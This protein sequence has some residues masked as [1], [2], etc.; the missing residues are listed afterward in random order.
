VGR[1]APIYGLNR[2]EK[3]A[4]TQPR[5]PS[6]M[7]FDKEAQ[8]LGHIAANQWCYGGST[9]VKMIYRV[10]WD[11]EISFHRVQHNV[12]WSDFGRLTV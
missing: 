8:D 4:T 9:G 6:A 3:G 11:N 5:S 10:C 1:A 12:E 7:L 2:K